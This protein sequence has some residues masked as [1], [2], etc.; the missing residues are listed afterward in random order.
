MILVAPN[1][2]L[3][4][5][6]VGRGDRNVAGPSLLLVAALVAVLAGPVA[7]GQAGV[8]LSAAGAVLAAVAVRR[9]MPPGM[10]AMRPGLPAATMALFCRAFRYFAVDGFVPLLLTS[11]DHRSVA[12]AGIVVTPAVLCWTL[13]G[14]CQA[15]LAARGWS[16]RRVVV[17]GTA[18]IIAGICG[19]A[20]GLLP[21]LWPAPYLAWAA[22]GFGMGLAYAA[23]WLAVMSAQAGGAGGLAAPLVADRLGTALGAGVGGVCI[24]LATGAGLSVGSGIG[25]G[26]AVAALAGSALALAARRMV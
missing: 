24:A 25:L 10:L 4:A 26:L 12:A 1:L 2:G 19:T 6:A 21:G 8:A 14:I 20:L 16:P 11:V 5:P 9:I 7:S 23:A 3:L 17:T 22:G 15:R 18:L 13:G